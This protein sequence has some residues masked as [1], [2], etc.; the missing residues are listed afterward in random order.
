MKVLLLSAL[1]CL[2][3]ATEEPLPFSG[4]YNTIYLASKRQS[5]TDENS[6]YR[7]LMREV[8]YFKNYKYMSMTFYVRKDGKCQIHK[9]W[10]DK[11]FY[12]LCYDKYYLKLRKC[13]Q[14]KG[15]A[16]IIG[17]WR[18]H[19]PYRHFPNMY[20]LPK[21]QGGI[22]R[23]PTDFHIGINFASNTTIL[24]EAWYTNNLGNKEKL[25]A[26]LA[27]GTNITEQMWKDYVNLNRRL[28]IPT[29]NINNV[30]KTDACPKLV[31]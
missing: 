6:E 24:L 14:R 19:E 12:N 21:P 16:N 11:V 2:V 9:A 7:M 10:A 4:S 20:Y 17:N 22:Q 8:N 28:K 31:Q 30:H 5:V 26:A 27:R 23:F 3:S 29:E 25:T 1:A 18:L 15:T 13:P